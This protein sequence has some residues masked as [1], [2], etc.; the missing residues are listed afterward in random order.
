M[1]L[2]DNGFKMGGSLVV[3]AGVVLLAP[4]VV[5]VLASVLRP[6]AK[7]A[8]KGVLLAYGKAKESVAETMETIEDL[9]VEAKSELAESTEKPAKTKKVAAAAA[10]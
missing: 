8:M 5:P 4:I 9:A 3:G 6:I 1:A 7:A 10:K 2:F